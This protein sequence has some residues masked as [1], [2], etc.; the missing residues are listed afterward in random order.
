LKRIGVFGGAFDPPHCAHLAL[1]Q[2]AIEQLQLDEL[3]IIPTGFAWH[4]DRSL[5]AAVHRLTMT[6]LAFSGLDRICIDDREIK[7]E[8]PSYTI[9][10]LDALQ[11]E[12]PDAAFFLLIGGDQLVAFAGW[13][14]WQDILSR[15]T[16]CVAERP[17]QAIAPADTL[18]QTPALRQ[19]IHL[20]LPPMTV[21]ATAI[22]QLIA[23]HT[24]SPNTSQPDLAGLVPDAVARYISLHG[25]YQARPTS[26]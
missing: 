12:E 23:S 15:A 9:D 20:Q 19:R 8:G 6:Q 13:H 21:S 1:A 11:A 22:R 16:I 7:R 5:S 2:A 4:K 25:L 17:L 3:K 24:G 10:T 26:S 18:V 14:R